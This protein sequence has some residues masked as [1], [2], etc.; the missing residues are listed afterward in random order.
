VRIDKRPLLLCVAIAAASCGKKPA[1]SPLDGAAPDG[2]APDGSSPDGAVPEIATAACPLV[3]PRGWHVLAGADSLTLDPLR[4]ERAYRNDYTGFSIVTPGE[5]GACVPPAA[6]IIR[7]LATTAAAPGPLYAL[8]LDTTNGT[9]ALH[10]SNDGGVGWT[11][12]QTFGALGQSSRLVVDEWTGRRLALIPG[13]DAP[14]RLSSDGGATFKAVRLAIEMATY[15]TFLPDAVVV[16]GFTQDGLAIAVSR[17]EGATWTTSSTMTG[18]VTEDVLPDGTVLLPS[19]GGLMRTTNAGATWTTQPT[20]G[21]RLART[22]DAAFLVREREILRSTDGGLTWAPFAQA[23]APVVRLDVAADQLTLLVRGDTGRYVS[24]DGGQTWTLFDVFPSP[25]TDDAAKHVAVGTSDGAIAVWTASGL[26]VS[27][28]DGR[29]WR[30]TAPP[31]RNAIVE[32]VV[33]DPARS[34]TIYL[35]QGAGT[36]LSYR[37]TDGGRTWATWEIAV[38]PRQPGATEA[39]PTVTNGLWHLPFT[40]LTIAP[41]DPRLMVAIA[42]R[43]VLRSTDGG[44]TWSRILTAPVAAPPPTGDAAFRAIAL[45]PSDPR[46]IYALRSDGRAFATTDGATT[47]RETM[48]EGASSLAV[49][50]IDPLLVAIGGA[51]GLHVSRDGGQTFQTALPDALS[52]IVRGFEPWSA[53]RLIVESSGAH[54]HRSNDDL[55]GATALVFHDLPKMHSVRE[56]VF[57]PTKPGRILGLNTVLVATNGD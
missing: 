48:L 51:K 45:A 22:R 54:Y 6:P 29:T 32:R 35:G 55:T 50:P 40:E 34:E 4:P 53:H 18:F 7:Q 25:R 9:D 31:D 36:A 49:S 39:T 8:T 26:A 13:V 44:A 57:V 23:P 15:V 16:S 24:R 1:I 19:S 30:A 5:A 27:A 12:L 3:P 20:Q 42:L 56:V 46:A 37:S 38:G 21:D 47:W 2:A 14:V 17:D 28:D 33:V 11:K 41:S 52:T 10:V 43:D